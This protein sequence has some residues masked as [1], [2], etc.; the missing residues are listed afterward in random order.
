ME[1][2]NIQ[3]NRLIKSIWIL[4][5]LG[6]FLFQQPA[7]AQM[8]VGDATTVTLHVNSG[9]L[10]VTGGNTVTLAVLPGTLYSYFFNRH[11]LSMRLDPPD[12][13][14][15]TNPGDLTWTMNGGAAQNVIFQF[16]LPNA[17]TSASTGGTI[18][19]SYNNTDANFFDSNGNY[20][21][22]DPRGPSAFLNLGPAGEA[23]VY[24]G[25]TFAIPPTIP[26]AS[27]YLAAFY[28]SAQST[29]F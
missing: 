8:N 14:G 6:V 5:V 22:W 21:F 15:N 27:D 12:V 3:G 20:F 9:G 7:S 17:F 26:A 18:P 29:G 13:D 2:M 16:V 11:D 10:M 28:L 1:N 4:L 19:I 25:F 24:L 23:I